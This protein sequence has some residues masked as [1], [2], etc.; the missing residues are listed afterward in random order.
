MGIESSKRGIIEHLGNEGSFS[1]KYSLSTRD[2]NADLWKMKLDTFKYI[3][4]TSFPNA[5]YYKERQ[6][7]NFNLPIEPI[8]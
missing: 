5:P 8:F 3:H 6:L 1:L 2:F 4:I 7:F